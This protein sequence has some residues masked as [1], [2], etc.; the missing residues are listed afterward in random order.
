M[1]PKE[2]HKH[3]QRPC[4]QRHFTSAS[5]NNVSKGMPQALPKALSPKAFHKRIHK[6]CLQS[7]A[8]KHYQRPC[9]QRHFTSAS[10]NNVS[11]G[12]PQALPKALSPKAFHKRIHKQCLQRNATSTT[13]GP[14]S[15]GIAQALPK[16]LSPKECGSTSKT[17]P[18]NI[19]CGIIKDPVSKYT[20]QDFILDLSIP[21]HRYKYDNPRLKN[22]SNT[23]SQTICCYCFKDPISKDMLWQFKYHIWHI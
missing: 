12:M 9:L 7:N 1:S 6:Q 17:P 15:K 22:T 23:L 13:K 14:V 2:C 8:P 3:Y 18:Q 4:L 5:I 19:W 16:T 11:K 20:E 21:A 10:I